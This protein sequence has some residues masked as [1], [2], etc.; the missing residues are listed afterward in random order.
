M[1]VTAAR[2]VQHGQP[3]QIEEVDLAEPGDQEAIL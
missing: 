2:L 3:L 1:R